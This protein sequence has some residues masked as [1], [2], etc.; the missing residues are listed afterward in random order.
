MKSLG[1]VYPINE[2]R[3]NVLKA[4]LINRGYDVSES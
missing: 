4:A 3:W 2:E 1:R